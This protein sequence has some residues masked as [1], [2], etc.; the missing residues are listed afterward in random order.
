MAAMAPCPAKVLDQL[1]PATVLNRRAKRRKGW[2]HY[3]LGFY[4]RANWCE[5]GIPHESWLV[6]WGLNP[7][8]KY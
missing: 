2:N 4:G 5:F 6:V 3:P 1:G 8:E 7:S